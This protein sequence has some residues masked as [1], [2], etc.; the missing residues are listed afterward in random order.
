MKCIL[1]TVE[2]TES[3]AIKTFNH[4]L[5][6]GFKSRF[7]QNEDGKYNIVIEAGTKDQLEEDLF[8]IKKLGYHNAQIA[9]L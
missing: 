8:D 2:E 4:L 9:I 5:S 1:V 7:K 6:W 3:D